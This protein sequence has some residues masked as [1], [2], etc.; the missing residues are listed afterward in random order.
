V[1]GVAATTISFATTAD[2]ST[3]KARCP[4]SI[5]PVWSNGQHTAKH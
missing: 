5:P 1:Y 3:V 4:S 2:W